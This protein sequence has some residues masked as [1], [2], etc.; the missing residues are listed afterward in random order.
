MLSEKEKESLKNI[1]QKLKTFDTKIKKIQLD[2]YFLALK[3]SKQFLAAYQLKDNDSI[4]KEQL[5][6]LRKFPYYYA[7]GL[8]ENLDEI[9][10]KYCD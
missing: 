2:M 10:Y 9:F 7:Q 5:E 6:C 8:I 4:S 1:C 3:H